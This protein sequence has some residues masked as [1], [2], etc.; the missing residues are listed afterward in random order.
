MMYDQDSGQVFKEW[1]VRRPSR[2]ASSADGWS[3]RPVHHKTKVR[4]VKGPRSLAQMAVTVIADNIGLMTPELLEAM[5]SRLLLLIWAYF[6]A[7]L[8]KS[9]IILSNLRM[10]S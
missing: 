10:Q 4:G 5:P 6:E 3:R 8:E 7:R 2:S 9:A 1:T